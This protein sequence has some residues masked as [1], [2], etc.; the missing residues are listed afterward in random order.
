MRIEP[1]TKTSCSKVD[2]SLRRSGPIWRASRPSAASLAIAAAA[3]AA[4]SGTAT[5]Q[6]GADQAGDAPKL[7]L[8]TEHRPPNNY[9]D[10]ESREVAG[11]NAEILRE[12]FDRA[13]LQAEFFLARWSRSY[14]RALMEPN[15]CVFSTVRNALR[16]PHFKWVGPIDQTVFVLMARKGE[17]IDLRSLDDARA[18]RIGVFTQDVREMM[19]RHRG[20]FDIDVAPEDQLN[21]RKLVEGRIDL[22]FTDTDALTEVGARDR[23]KMTVALQLEGQDLYLACNLGVADKIIDKLN[24]ALRTMDLA[25]GE[26][27]PKAE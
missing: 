16:E 2:C 14:G 11:R 26:D 23:A 7:T 4:M 5:A 1:R 12:A 6:N 25:I 21:A 20:G 9:Q 15:T 13:G 3:A 22:W 18:Y 8:M 24:V 27:V 17:G 19:L 10:P